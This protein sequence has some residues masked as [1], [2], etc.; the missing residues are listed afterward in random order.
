MS[1]NRAPKLARALLQILLR[2]EERDV[3]LGDLDEEFHADIFPHRSRWAAKRW[4][5]RQ[6]VASV[7]SRRRQGVVNQTPKEKFGQDIVRDLRFATR[8]LRKS[9]GFSAAAIAT[10]AL[11]IGANTAIFTVVNAVMFTPLPYQEPDRLVFLWNRTAT[12]GAHRMPVAA[13]DVAEYREQTSLFEGFAFSDRVLDAAL[14]GDGDPEHIT[15]ARV[16]PN[17]F[18]ILGVQPAVGRNFRPQEGFIPPADRNDTTVVI[19]PNAVMLSHGFWQR[20]FGASGDVIG[21]T[22]QISGQRTTVVGVL[23]AD[24]EL[25]LPPDVGMARRVDA[26]SPLRFRLGEF[27]RPTGLRDRDS[28]NTGAVIGRLRPGVTLAQAQAEMDG[29]AARQR[30]RHEYHRT[31]GMAIDV[32]SLH[33]DV[34]QHVR[35]VLFVLFGAV[36][37]VM[38]IACINVANLL[39]ARAADRMQEMRLRTALGASRG[40]LVRQLVTESALLGALGGAAGLLLAQ[41]GIGV[42]MAFRPDNLPRM[43]EIGIDGT[44]LAFTMG[45]VLVAALL[46]SVAPAFDAAIRDE[47]ALVRSRTAGAGTRKRLRDTLVVSE[48]ALSLVLLVGAGLLFRSLAQLQRVEPGFQPGGVLAFDV[49]LRHQGSYRGPAERS[50]FISQIGE[51]IRSLPGVQSVG[52]IGRLPLGGRQWTQPYGLEGQVPEEWNA[53]EANFRVVTADYFDAMG[54]RL[55]AGRHFVGEDDRQDL[56]VTIIDETMARRIARGQNVLGKTIGFPLDGHPVWAQIVGVVENVHHASL[57][58]DSRETIYVP[59]RHEASREVSFVVR[60]GTDPAALAGPIRREIQSLASHLPIYNVHTMSDY[61][62]RSIGADRFAFRLI[63]IF[64]LLAVT[65]ASI[66]LYGVI[67]YSVQQRTQEIG[68]R[69]ALGAGRTSVMK[70]V[71]AKGMTLAATGLLIGTAVSIVGVRFSSALLFGV[72]GTDP[73][74]YL[75]VST[76]LMGVAFLAC[77]IPARRA[78]AVDPM[79]AL[80]GE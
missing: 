30:A 51:R 68:I 49:T 5:W 21:Q 28:D 75:A 57:R 46:F 77:Y 20:R 48:V 27:R 56:R 22:I 78:S 40:R 69:M 71:V 64:A 55:V 29:I 61:L 9:P 32:R 36:A 26:W 2:G 42:L 74:T 45:S 4:Y 3:I 7:I 67:S 52:L 72:A 63:G 33:D 10:L 76:L 1:R 35:P 38:L 43:S 31:A 79:L 70:Q 23:P 37:F 73:P 41:W 6:V 53:N 8:T 58:Q 39:L 50:Q 62:S 54:T 11:G 65:L 66:G 25:L 14:T 19:A 13:P 24:F 18:S 15:V 44:A 80:R 16:T 59:Y 12:A 17:F 47:R 60:A 34:V